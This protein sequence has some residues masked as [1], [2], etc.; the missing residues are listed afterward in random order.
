MLYLTVGI[1]LSG[2]LIG[3]YLGVGFGIQEET[4]S[5]TQVV[6]LEQEPTN[7]PDTQKYKNSPYNSANATGSIFQE[8]DLIALI[9]GTSRLA[10]DSTSIYVSDYNND[11][12]PDILTIR[13]SRAALYKNNEGELTQSYELSNITFNESLQA[14]LFFDYNNNGYQDL[15]LLSGSESKFLENKKGR[16]VRKKVGLGR[17]YEEVRSVA[18]A[19]YTHNGCLDI[20]VAQFGNLEENRPLGFYT[21]N[22]SIGEDNGA[23]NV[24][25]EGDC[26][27]FV[28]ST[29]RAGIRGNTW[30]HATSFVDFT[31]DGYPDIH[32]ANDFNNDVIYTNNRNGTFERHILP[33]FTN[34][35]GM[36]SEIADINH[37]GYLDIFVTN[38]AFETDSVNWLDNK[39][40][41]ALVKDIFE[42]RSKGNNLLINQGGGEFVDRAEEYGVTKGGIGWSALFEDFDND[43][44]QELV[45]AD[46]GGVSGV[47]AS[48]MGEYEVDSPPNMWDRSEDSFRRLSDQESGLTESRSYGIVAL[49]YDVDGDFDVVTDNTAGSFKLYENK[50][51]AS[52]LQLRLISG[53][54]TAIGSQVE[55]TYQNKT[56]SR[57]KTSESDSFSQS[58]RV[59]HFGV[60]ESESIDRITID[61]RG[62]ST[63][64][65]EDLKTNQ[66]LIVSPDHGIEDTISFD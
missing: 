12:F 59:L 13:G 22:V 48:G 19:D 3:V 37:D 18:A 61:W 1:L 51:E 8:R 64:V 49:D 14:A 5:N 47:Y 44:E 31:N 39:N 9:N 23:G 58:S 20:F 33:E 10:R 32:V 55:V 54:A 35:N 11:G 66:R 46:T 4:G 6:G 53:N 30:S 27:E 57:A 40:G 16:F 50:N 36:S 52:S 65:Y 21:S 56:V 24:L 41:T 17:G 38:I 15:Y 43:G 42:R 7:I 29:G 34:R 63:D 45:H 62:G 25:F 26:K 2:V 60:G 28:E